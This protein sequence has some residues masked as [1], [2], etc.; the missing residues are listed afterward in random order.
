MLRETIMQLTLLI[1]IGTAKDLEDTLFKHWCKIAITF[2]IYSKWICYICVI[3]IPGRI[4]N[5]LLD[6]ERGPMKDQTC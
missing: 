5:Y 6:K 3:K 2:S 4:V 1:R